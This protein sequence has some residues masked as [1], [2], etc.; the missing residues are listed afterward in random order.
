MK[1]GT[2]MIGKE[3]NDVI[4]SL[5]RNCGGIESEA[6]IVISVAIPKDIPMGTVNNKSIA[7]L[8]NKMIAVIT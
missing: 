5:K 1:K 8:A 4:N 2:A 6:T 7:K 3:S